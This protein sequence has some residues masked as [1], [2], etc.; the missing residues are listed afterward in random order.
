MTEQSINS[1]HIKTLLEFLPLF[2]MLDGT[3]TEWRGGEVKDGV[4]LVP[5]PVYPEEVSKFF[6]LAGQSLWAD[7]EY[8]RNN[9]REILDD[10][11]KIAKAGI[12]QIKTMLTYCAR[13]ERFCDGLQA[14]MIKNGKIVAVLR[15]LKELSTQYEH[16]EHDVKRH[17]KKLTNLDAVL[18]ALLLV[19]GA[20]RTVDEEDVAVKANEIAPGRFTW[21]KYPQQIN[22]ANVQTFL[23][24]AK[25]E[26]YGRLASGSGRTGWSLT[27]DGL[28]HAQDVESRFARAATIPTRTRTHPLDKRRHAREHERLLTSDAYLK[29]QAT[30]IDSVTLAEAEAFFRLDEYVAADLRERKITRV[31]S[32]IGTDD[33]ELLSAATALAACVRLPT[34]S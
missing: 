6:K 8:L 30:G 12:E 34:Q 3:D 26:K 15:R 19:G 31:L 27:A 18:L 24:D 13:G 9:P 1:K 32:S 28:A 2:E 14:T 11:Q 23:R 22:I 29:F 21:R 10:P 17:P 25:K 16:D 33:A 4:M 7:Y 20:E 5:H